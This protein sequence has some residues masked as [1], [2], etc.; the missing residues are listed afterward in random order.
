MKPVLAVMS[1]PFPLIAPACATVLTPLDPNLV[2]NT[3]SS[4]SS[5]QPAL[6]R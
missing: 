2:D 3:Y 1:L 5:S 4:V 6:V